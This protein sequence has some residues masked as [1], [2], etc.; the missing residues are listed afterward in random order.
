MKQGRIVEEGTH[1]ELL[2]RGGEYA[3]LHKLQFA[4]A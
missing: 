3:R 1:D 4:E 2:A